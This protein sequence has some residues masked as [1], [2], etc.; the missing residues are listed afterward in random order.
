MVS[1]D[2]VFFCLVHMGI[3]GNCVAGRMMYPGCDLAEDGAQF[4]TNVHTNV[5]PYTY[6]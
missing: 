5:Y 6:V 2:V 3:A 1:A 4:Y